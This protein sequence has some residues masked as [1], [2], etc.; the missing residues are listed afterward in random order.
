MSTKITVVGA[1]NVG[2][3][4]A[5]RLAELGIANEVVRLASCPDRI[6][7]SQGYLVSTCRSPRGGAGRARTSG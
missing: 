4:T 5:Q 6:M 1:G 7:P 2:A 3:T